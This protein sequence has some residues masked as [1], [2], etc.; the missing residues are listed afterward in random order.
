MAPQ[1]EHRDWLD[2]H[3]PIIRLGRTLAKAGG[4]AVKRMHA[5]D[6]EVSARIDQAVKFALDSPLPKA[7]TAFDHVFA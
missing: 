5:L 3:D 6:A 2:Q 7:E 1:G 4:D